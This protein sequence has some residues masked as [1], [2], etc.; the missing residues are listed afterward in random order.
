MKA[1]INPPTID[2]DVTIRM[3]ESEAKI[4]RKVAG[5]NV[6]VGNVVSVSMDKRQEISD[7]LRNVF[8]TLGDAGIEY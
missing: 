8:H 5:S 3:K 7:V 1:E 4:L 6:S 2:R